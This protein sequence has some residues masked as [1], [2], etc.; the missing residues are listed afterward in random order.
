MENKPSSFYHLQIAKCGG[1][2]LNNVIIHQL[3]NILKNNNISYI[4]GEYH[5]GW[6]EIENNYVVS[7]LRDPVKRTV[8]HYAYWKN[9]GNDKTIPKNI[10]SFMVWVKINK[11]FISNY[12]IK[13]FLYTKK[14]IALNAFNPTSSIDPDFL[15]I[16]IDKNLALN[17]IKN[18]NIL[19]K[20]TQLNYQTCEMVI[21]KILK[22]FNIKDKFYIDN[23]KQYDHNIKKESKELYESLTKQDIEYL[24]NLNNIDSEI[25]FSKSIYFSTKEF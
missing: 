1:T 14:N 13:N 20:D 25:Y 6:K 19:L 22:D 18:T 4:D 12:Q 24:Y 16:H 7:S 10:P 9:G 17:R 21:K 11:N 3:F 5:L 23:K 2:Y 15:A 8:S